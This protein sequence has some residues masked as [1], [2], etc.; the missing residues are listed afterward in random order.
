MDDDSDIIEKYKNMSINERKIIY[1]KNRKMFP[2][3]SF[4]EWN[5]RLPKPKKKVQDFFKK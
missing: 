2:D 1:N 3:L 4:T 5:A